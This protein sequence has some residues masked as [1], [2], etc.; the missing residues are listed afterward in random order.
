[1]LCP[2][3]SCPGPQNL[4]AHCSPPTPTPCQSCSCWPSPPPPTPPPVL[5]RARLCYAEPRPWVPRAASSA[6]A[7]R[8]AGTSPLGTRMGEQVR[9]LGICRRGIPALAAPPGS[10]WRHSRAC[11]TC[12]TCFFSAT[13]CCCCVGNTWRQPAAGRVRRTTASLSLPDGS[14]WWS[15][16]LAPS[17]AAWVRSAVIVAQPVMQFIKMS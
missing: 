17:D 13:R 10:V 11:A 5:L 12:H 4:A 6:R 3:V 15:R 2:H 14:A 16:L 1:M 8:A 7:R 9:S